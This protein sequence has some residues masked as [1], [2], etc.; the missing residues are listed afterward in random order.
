[1]EWINTIISNIIE[2]AYACLSLCSVH[3]VRLS[4]LMH[5]RVC[6]YKRLPDL[7]YV[8]MYYVYLYSVQNARVSIMS[9][10]L[11]S[12]RHSQQ[13]MDTAHPSK[14][15]H[16]G[17]KREPQRTTVSK[18]NSCCQSDYVSADISSSWLKRITSQQHIQ[19]KPQMIRT[20]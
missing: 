19:N 16:A 6:T 20:T 5:E 7:Y 12:L 18:L 14:C 10:K 3:T 15:D 2:Q 13:T 9:L 1:M 11:F 8:V 4:S 17:E